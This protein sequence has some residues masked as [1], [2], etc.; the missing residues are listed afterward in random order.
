MKDLPAYEAFTIY[1]NPGD[2]KPTQLKIGSVWPHKNSSG[3]T[4]MLSVLPISSDLLLLPLQPPADG[5]PAATDEPETLIAF[6]VQK[7]EGQPSRWTVLG[8]AS[9]HAK[10]PGYTVKLG[11]LPMN[12]EIVLRPPKVS[13]SNQ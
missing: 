6:A 1:Q 4:I 10:K 11:A 7:I 13:G 5:L 3:F 8:S 9:K 12:A 2:D